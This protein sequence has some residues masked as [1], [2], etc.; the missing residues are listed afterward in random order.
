L[1]DLIIDKLRNQLPRPLRRLLSTVLVYSQ[2]LIVWLHVVRQVKGKSPVDRKI[3]WYG[4]AR[5]PVTALQHTDRWT[6]PEVDQNCVVLVRGIGEFRVRAKCDDL[7]HVLPAREPA[8]LRT[9]RETLRE[10]D[11]FIDAGANIGFYTILASRLV[12]SRGRVIAVEMMPDTAGIL[13]EHLELNGCRN[14]TIIEKA[15][16]EC[17]GDKV[18]AFVQSGKFG[19]ASITKVQPGQAIEVETITLKDV[20][21]DTLVVKLIKMDLEGAEMSALNSLG[22]SAERVQKI[23]FEDWGNSEVSRFFKRDKYN[24]VRLDGN[25]S[26]AVRC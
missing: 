4:A 25:N 2:R 22:D 24:V 9:I 5:A 16:S 1:I 7:Y 14:V 17:S 13:R 10:G 21:S 15:V 12:G 20:I 8:I 6:N 19:Q 11:V 26:L 23:I 18:S 3:I